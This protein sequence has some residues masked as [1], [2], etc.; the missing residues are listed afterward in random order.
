M[1]G[2]RRSRRPARRFPSPAQPGGRECSSYKRTQPMPLSLQDSH[3][4]GCPCPL[5]HPSSGFGTFETCTP[6]AKMSRFW[7]T[8]RSDV[9]T[10]KMARRTHFGSKGVTFPVHV[11]ASPSALCRR[12]NRSQTCVVASRSASSCRSTEIATRKS[13]QLFAPM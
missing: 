8:I 6:T 7:E 4:Q 1:A 9:P 5:A 2:R 12:W 10:V 3:V 11:S 13:Y